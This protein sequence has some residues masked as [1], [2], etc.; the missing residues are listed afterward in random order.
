[1]A[2][3]LKYTSNKLESRNPRTKRGDNRR[4]K[5]KES[6]SNDIKKFHYKMPVFGSR[7]VCATANY[8]YVEARDKINAE[9]EEGLGR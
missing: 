9:R 7:M 4:R 5:D 8:K 6:N 3:E 2:R 1:M